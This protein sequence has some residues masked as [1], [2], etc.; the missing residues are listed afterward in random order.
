MSDYLHKVDSILDEFDFDKVRTV[1]K[2]LNW[3]YF[4][5]EEVPTISRIYRMARSLLISAYTAEP[6][7]EWSTACGGFEVTRY[8]YPGDTE[9]YVTLKFVVTEWSSNND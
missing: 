6:S 5:S 9:K 7:Q 8:M 1:M 2:A 3:T 4:D